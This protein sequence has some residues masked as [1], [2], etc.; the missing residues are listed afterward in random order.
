MAI[1][2]DKLVAHFDAPGVRAIVLM[3]SHARGE[4]GPYSDID[5]V[6]FT[7]GV[8]IPGA[9]SHLY[10][11]HLLVVSNVPPGEV[12]KC[13]SEPE[14]ATNTIAG[15]RRTRV[16][17][18]RADYFAGIQVRAR[19]F[20][21]DEAMQGRANRWASEMMVGNAEEARKGLEGL[22]RND[23]GR[24]LNACFGFSWSMSRVM[25]VQR[26]V[27]L[28][29]DNGLYDEVAQAMSEQPEWVSLRRAAFGIEDEHGQALSLREQ[30]QA[31]LRLYALTAELLAPVLLPEHRPLIE[32]T[33]SLIRGA[34]K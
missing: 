29:G 24:M 27:L 4:A 8:D 31:G 32:H 25:K 23:I 19:A 9:D 21:W 20:V 15:L 22:R 7:D 16:L 11:G 14:A 1:A 30:V 26:G 5:L 13:F 28:S 10:H 18:D 34:V 33:V 6:R 17:L 12:E 3:G 2:F